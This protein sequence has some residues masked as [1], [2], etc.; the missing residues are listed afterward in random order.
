MSSQRPVPDRGHR[1]LNCGHRGL[2]GHILSRHGREA[3]QDDAIIRSNP[4][5][6]GGNT[7]IGLEAA[8][9]GEHRL[10]FV[11]L[12]PRISVARPMT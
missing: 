9:G 7:E 1:L 5:L 8:H 10:C 3:A 4:Y 2:R 11:E 6:A 12:K